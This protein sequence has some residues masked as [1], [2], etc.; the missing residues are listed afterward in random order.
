MP[1]D[2]MWQFL[3]YPVT[4]QEFYEGKTQENKTKPFFDFR[5]SI[6]VHLS[7]DSMEQWI[8]TANR[9]EKNGMKNSMIFDRF[10]HLKS[11]IEMSKQKG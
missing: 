4:N 11:E 9:I 2:Y 1:F 5:D 8:S 7:K 10:H 3:P 6:R